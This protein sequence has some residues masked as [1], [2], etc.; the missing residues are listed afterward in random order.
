MGIKLGRPETPE[1]LGLLGPSVIFWG[2]G[3]KSKNIYEVCIC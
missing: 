1:V 3:A 2:D